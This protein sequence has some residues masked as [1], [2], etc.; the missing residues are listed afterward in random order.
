MRTS[1]DRVRQALLFETIGLILSVPLAAFIFHFPL[2]ETGVLGLIG[3]TL[4]T[5]WN[6]LFNLGFDLSLKRF[7]GSTR[8]SVKVRFLHAISFETGLMIAFLPIIAW[9]MDISVIDALIV[10]IS[11]VVF[12]LVYAFIFTWCYDIIFPDRD[13]PESSYAGN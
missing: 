9:W 12:Y 13:T 1:K 4:A 11:F 3:A 10:D 2:K 6:Y 5:C 7:T 8:K